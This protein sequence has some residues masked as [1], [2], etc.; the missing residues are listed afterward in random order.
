[1]AKKQ[2]SSRLE[3]HRLTLRFLEADFQKLKYWAD[4][5]G[6]SVNEF[7]I[8]MLEQWVD[9]KNGNYEL[10]TLEVQ[11]LN[12]L[13]EAHSVMARDL[14]SLTSVVVSGF[15]SLLSLTRG[16]NYL[17]QDEDGE[18]DFSSE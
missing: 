17:L 4:K 6:V 9:I 11:R 13:I 12:Q 1:M 10:P 7:I 5:E 18:L 8:L 14:Q 2:D 16:D 15:D 3:Q